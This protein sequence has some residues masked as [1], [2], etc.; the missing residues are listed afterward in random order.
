MLTGTKIGKHKFSGT[1]MSKISYKDQNRKCPHLQGLKLEK[2]T[3]KDQKW[4]MLTYKD[5]K[6]I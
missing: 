3:Y 1:K 2:W 6:Y 4:K 5:Q